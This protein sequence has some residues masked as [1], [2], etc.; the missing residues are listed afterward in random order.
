MTNDLFSIFD[1]LLMKQICLG[2]LLGISLNS[3]LLLNPAGAQTARLAVVKSPDN[4]GYWSEITKRLA[5]TGINYC[6]VD[7]NQ[8]QQAS[9][10]GGT[11][12]LF[13][14]NIER[15]EPVQLAALQDW[16]NQGGQVI[17]SGA[18]GTMSRPAIR[19]R[20]RSLFGAYWGFAL[21]EPAT[22]EI[23]PTPTQTWIQGTGLASKIPG[24]VV[25]PASLNSTTAAVWNQNDKPPAVVTTNQ[26][27]FFGWNWGMDQIV[28]TEVDTA[29]LKAALNYYHITP[30]F[31]PQTPQQSISYCGKPESSVIT[32]NPVQTTEFNNNSP[33]PITSP[34]APIEPA[35]TSPQDLLKLTPAQITAMSQELENLIGRFESTLLTANAANS[36]VQLLTSTTIEQISNTTAKKDPPIQINSNFP[37]NNNKQF[38]QAIAEARTGLQNFLN[39]AAQQNYTLARLEWLKARR[40]LWD[41]YPINHQLTQPEIRAIWL[42]RGTIVKA[43]SEQDLAKIFDQIAAAGFNT[44]FFETL[45][46]SYPIYPS[47]VAPEQNPLVRGWDP[48]QAAVKLAHERGIEL[49]AWVWIFAAANQRHNT[50]LNQPLDYPGPVLAT[51]PDWAIFDKQGLL[52]DPTT[53]R[54]SLTQLIQKSAVI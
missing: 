10:F 19:N 34:D 3:S 54:H 14:P 46:A 20:L 28:S 8:V 29:W 47:R 13:L 16:M 39:A 33:P 25:I 31:P 41:N 50:L 32:T 44:V 38:N 36:N 22:I 30:N 45:N 12:I 43:K 35:Q 7:W 1:Q 11:Q 49:H 37:T 15:L 51:H 17:V 21:S 26:S 5:S 40:I 42:D 23:M 18:A 4:Q 52:F 48:L 9:D 24:G 53:K 6:I 27:I 2:I